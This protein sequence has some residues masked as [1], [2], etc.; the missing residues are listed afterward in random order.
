MKQKSGGG[1]PP[2]P[3]S[4]F[5][6]EQPPDLPVLDP[7]APSF[8]NDQSNLRSLN[9][10]NTMGNP[11]SSLD[12]TNLDVP[13]LVPNSPGNPANNQN[14]NTTIGPNSLLGGSTSPG[15]GGLQPSLQGVKVPDENL[16]PQQRQHRENSL[17]TI[18]KM[19]MMFFAEQQKDDPN[20]QMDP[21]QPGPPMPPGG[22]PG[23]MPPVSTPGGPC[24]NNID[25]NINKLQPSFLDGKNKVSFLFLS[26][27]TLLRK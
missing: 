25:W 9:G 3:N 5:P 8:W 22:I 10:S 1:H 27:S 20:A 15:P 4:G 2:P 17:A 19:Q 24:P 11:E 18:R 16:T 6:T 12:D 23:N 21:N 26:K 7:N 14:P 13:C